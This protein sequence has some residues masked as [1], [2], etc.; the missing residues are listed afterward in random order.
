[1]RLELTRRG[2]YGI[3][4]MLALARAPED[5]RVSVSSIA[6]D[7]RIPVRFL[8]SAMGDLVAAGLVEGT[9]G[10]T[11]G[12]RLARPASSITLL[13]VIEAVE[14][15]PR[16]TTCVLRGSPC[17]VA[18]ACDVHAVFAAAQEALLERLAATTLAEIVGGAERVTARTSVA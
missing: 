1:M 16:R 6:A 7:H 3:R 13:D 5:R 18:G 11:G 2:D 8:P 4:A 14:G 12:Y 17:L 9:A 15:D 10:R